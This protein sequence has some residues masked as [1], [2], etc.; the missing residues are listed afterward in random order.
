V[1]ALMPTNGSKVYLQIKAKS[2]VNGNY[3]DP[4]GIAYGYD[5]VNETS[6][7]NGTNNYDIWCT[8]GGSVNPNVWI[9]NW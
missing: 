4:F 9:R 2:L 6:L 5:Y 3:V 8:V 7:Y 1:A